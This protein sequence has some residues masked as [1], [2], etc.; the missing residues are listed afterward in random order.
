MDVTLSNPVVAEKV[1]LMWEF[2][3]LKSLVG[4][5]ETFSTTKGPLEKTHKQTQNIFYKPWD[6]DAMLLHNRLN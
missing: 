1:A 5:K 3:I 2:S 6:C 4:L